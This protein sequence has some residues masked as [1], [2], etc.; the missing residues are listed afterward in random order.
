MEIFIKT[1]PAIIAKSSQSTLGVM[2]LLILM[3]TGLSYVFFGRS[4]DSVKTYA[5]VGALA[6]FLFIVATLRASSRIARSHPGHEDVHRIVGCAQPLGGGFLGVGCLA[7]ILTAVLTFVGY[8][9]LIV[10]SLLAAA[11]QQPRY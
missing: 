8:V 6:L 10:V 7:V 11:A 9:V 3:M 5:Y 1:L 2:S 4:P